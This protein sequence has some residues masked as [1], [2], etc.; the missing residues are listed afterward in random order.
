METEERPSKI[1]KLCTDENDDIAHGSQSREDEYDHISQPINAQQDAKGHIEN[2][3]IEKVDE[4]I[5]SAAPETPPLS[6][7]QLKKLRRKQEWEDGKEFRKARRKEKNKKRKERERAEKDAEPDGEAAE[8][9]VDSAPPSRRRLQV[10][11]TFI[12]D[13]DFDDLMAE[14]EIKSLATQITRCYSEN[15]HAPFRAHMALSSFNGNLKKRFQTVLADHHKSWRGVKFLDEDFVE[16]SNKAR[17]W[18]K[19][20]G[21]G[22]LV[23]SFA[24]TSEGEEP[25]SEVAEVIYL[26]S[27]SEET[28]HALQPYSTYIIGGLVDK[29]RHKG[30]CYKRALG[31]GVKTA[32]LPI[33]E[34]M[35][36]NSRHILTTNHVYEIL[37]RWLELGDW[38]EAF[39][40]VMPKRKGGVLKS[41]GHDE[42]VEKRPDKKGEQLK[43]A[44]GVG[45]VGEEGAEG[46][47]QADDQAKAT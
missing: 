38:G 11:V 41:S 27:D 24:T 32:K 34:F 40:K 33:G 26:T 1:R 12:I 21:G 18:M 16:T 22:Q 30:I 23:G 25:I 31:K 39:T 6:K 44:E 3:V 17:Q 5:N 7:N 37:I 4:A 15:N 28:L 43:G 2:A 14:N 45:E 9:S 10:P 19:G 29:N 47:D 20:K 46:D 42:V 36:M 13:C 8:A 35:E